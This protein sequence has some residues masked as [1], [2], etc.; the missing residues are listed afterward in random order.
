MTDLLIHQQHG[1]EL[2]RANCPA[3]FARKNDSPQFELTTGFERSIGKLRKE[4]RRFSSNIRPPSP[5][6]EHA[7]RAVTLVPTTTKQFGDFAEGLL[8][9]GS[10]G[11]RIGTGQNTS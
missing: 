5:L 2:G 6:T 11:G 9:K 10:R 1:R 3:V 4:F 7:N 8:Q